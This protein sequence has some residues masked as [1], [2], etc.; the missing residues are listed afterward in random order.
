MTL[1]GG[2]LIDI[3]G[4]GTWHKINLNQCHVYWTK[5]TDQKDTYDPKHPPFYKPRSFPILNAT[6][7]T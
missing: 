1:L 6:K 4:P 3:D 7:V 5:V 2:L